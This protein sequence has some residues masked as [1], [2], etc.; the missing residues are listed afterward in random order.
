MTIGG[1]Y[2]EDR[3]LEMFFRNQKEGF[4]VDVGAADGEDNSNSLMLLKRP[5]WRGILIEPEPKQFSILNE[6]YARNLN[7]RCVNC[8]I[9]NSEDV[10][11][12]LWC[13]GQGSTLNHEWKDRCEKDYGTVYDKTVQVDILTLGGLLHTAEMVADP[14]IDSIDFLS[15]DCEGMDYDVLQSL[16]FDKWQPRLIC[17]E[18]RG[19]ALPENYS[20]FC[21]TKGNTFYVR[22]D[23]F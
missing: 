16:D 10:S 2:G 11:G 6:R 13:G 21:L 3:I 14:P 7:V 12:M 1:Q 22:D 20:E 17:I 9:S 5:D 23:E 19:Y 15:I 4:V 8:A 18:G